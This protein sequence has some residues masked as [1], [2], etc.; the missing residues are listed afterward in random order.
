M[1]FAKVLKKSAPTILSCLAGA[2]VIFT[3]IEAV[4][5]TPKAIKR[6]ENA[7]EEKGEPL[8]K[9]EVVKVT[10]SCYTKTAAFGVGT[11]V[12]IFAANVINRKLQASMTGAYVLL[13][14]TYGDYISKIKERYGEKVHEEIMSEVVAERAS[15]VSIYA[16]NFCGNCNTDFEGIMEETCL[17]YDSFSNRYFEATPMQVIQAEY[18]LN[19]NF[20]LGMIPSVNDFYDLLG[21]EHTDIGKTLG[22]TN[23]NGDYYWIDFN[24]YKAKYNDNLECYVIEC[25][26]FSA[27]TPEFLE[28]I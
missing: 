5:D 11:I 6:V 12:C 1:N 22:W 15:D 19:R 17:F 8:T 10:W 2:G 18:H 27:P 3:A 13:E 26:A 20:A 24:H 16:E 9:K 21:L 25:C 28:D 4:K 23:S 7:S 14:R